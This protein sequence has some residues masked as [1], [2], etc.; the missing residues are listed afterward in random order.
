MHFQAAPGIYN[1]AIMNWMKKKSIGG[2]NIVEISLVAL[3]VTIPYGDNLNSYTIV[4]FAALCLVSSKFDEKEKNLKNQPVLRLLPVLYYVW[5]CLRLFW[6]HPVRLSGEYLESKLSL[7]AFPLL[8]GS[9]NKVSRNAIKRIFFSFVL[10]NIAA[11]VY[12]LWKAYGDYGARRYMGAFFYHNLSSHIGLNAIYFSMYA[13]FCIFILVYYFLT[14]RTS[15]GTQILTMVSI[16]YL[17]IIVILLSSK[18]FIFL[19]YLTALCTTAY[20]YFYFGTIKPGSAIMFIFLLAIPVLLVKFSFVNARI[21]QT[22]LQEYRGTVDD[23]NGLAVRGVLWKSSVNLIFE[24]PVLGWGH[25]GGEE[26]LRMQLSAAGFEEGAKKN[27]NSHN[28]YLFS[29]LCFGLPGVI[30]IITFLFT[31]LVIFIKRRQFLGIYLAAS[32]ILANITECLIETQKGIVFFL[33]FSTLVMFHFMYQ[34]T[35][36]S[37]QG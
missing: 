14:E 32:F 18:M 26:S 9:M 4:A 36:R 22:K 1:S 10:T 13:V 19:L 5:L 12:C 7:I 8:L 27:Y 28:Q 30:L 3:A 29:W 35:G 15:R 31:Y 11:S 16:L 24:R 20:S 33:F 2:L 34:K 17:L 23:Q 6:D 21:A 25:S 37:V